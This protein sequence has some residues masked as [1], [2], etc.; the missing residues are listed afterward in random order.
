MNN[1]PEIHFEKEQY[2]YVFGWDW[3][4]KDPRNMAG[5]FLI[6]FFDDY[7]YK[8]M[9]QVTLNGKT[10]YPGWGYYR[11]HKVFRIEK[12]GMGRE[13]YVPQTSWLIPIFDPL[14]MLEARKKFIDFDPAKVCAENRY[15]GKMLKKVEK[16]LDK[17]IQ[18]RI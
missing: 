6:S 13:I 9:T 12:D 18:I 1:P 10:K 3:P 17:G 2:V 7:G 16:S 14:N 4:P 15:F 8:W 11:L 5:E